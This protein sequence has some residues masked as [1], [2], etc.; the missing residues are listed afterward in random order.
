MQIH[1]SGLCMSVCISPSVQYGI[2]VADRS[3]LSGTE[4]LVISICQRKIRKFAFS[5]MYFVYKII[6]EFGFKIPR[7]AGMFVLEIEICSR[8]NFTLL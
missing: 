3:C 1:I 7:G 6:P 4:L 2:S 5:E 8:L